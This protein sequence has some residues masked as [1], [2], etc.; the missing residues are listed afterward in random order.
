MA[1][2]RGSGS[3]MAGVGGGGDGYGS[4]NRNVGQAC[5]DRGLRD[6]PGKFS[7]DHGTLAFEGCTGS[8]GG[9]WIVTCA[10]TKDSWWL[11]QQL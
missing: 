5:G 9:V 6:I 10:C 1:D 8:Q 4:Y 2:L 7:L 3:L 11:Q